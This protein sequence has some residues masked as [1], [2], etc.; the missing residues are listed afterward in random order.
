MYKV[1][2]EVFGIKIASYSVTSLVA[3]FL[4]AL[5]MRSE[6]KRKGWRT[7]SITWFTIWC[8]CIG[9]AGAHVFY[10]FMRIGI[11]SWQRW[12]LSLLGVMQ[13]GYVW[14]GG[15][16]AAAIYGWWYARWKKIPVLS[17]FDS[18]AIGLPIALG[19]GRIGC[20]M[21]GCCL[22]IRTELP[23]GVHFPFMR[24]GYHVHPAQLYDMIYQYL[25]F[26]GLWRIRK[27]AK[28]G[29]IL[30]FYLI[31]VAFGRFLLEY[32]RSAS[33]KDNITSWLSVDQVIA[34]AIAA[35]GLFLYLHLRRAELKPASSY[36]TT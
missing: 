29:Y 15:V 34:L 30:S 28:P 12:L 35:A 23:W 19:T 4:C 13:S 5:I 24:E 10:V 6:A 9:F 14:H 20:F 25:L 11:M 33:G 7:D 32:V 31:F 26:Y 16:M 21:A 8:Y 22:G 3:F 36:S 17:L 2:F 18:G 27:Q 1:L